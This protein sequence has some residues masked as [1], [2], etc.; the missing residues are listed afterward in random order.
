M[1]F[2]LVGVRGPAPDVV[3]S[4]DGRGPAVVVV[5]DLRGGPSQLNS[6]SVRWTRSC[7]A[8]IELGDVERELL[9]GA[10]QDRR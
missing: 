2:G 6:W 8:R 3:N 4:K 10:L 7:C 5:G 1:P 9:G